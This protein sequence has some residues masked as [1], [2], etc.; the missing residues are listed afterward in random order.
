M[1]ARRG[2]FV[3]RC[4]WFGARLSPPG[5]SIDVG[6][7]RDFLNGKRL[8]GK[9]AAFR[10]RRLKLRAYRYPLTGVERFALRRALSR[11]RKGPDDVG[12]APIVERDWEPFANDVEA[13]EFVE[14]M[15]DELL[16]DLDEA[17]GRR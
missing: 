16:A 9:Q 17:E 4:A 8:G 5:R 1:A 3:A 11:M 13:M 2:G 12:P 7:E 15:T 10:A 14:A 6:A